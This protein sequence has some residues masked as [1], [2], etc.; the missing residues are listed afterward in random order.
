[1]FHVFELRTETLRGALLPSSL[2]IGSVRCTQLK[3]RN[4]ASRSLPAV[5]PGTG[6]RELSQV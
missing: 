1:M 2:H 3:Y 6:H 4:Q 5:S